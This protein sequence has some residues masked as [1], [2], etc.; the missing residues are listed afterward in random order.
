MSV[1]AFRSAFLR[2]FANYFWRR[3]YSRTTPMSLI[4]QSGSQSNAAELN[5]DQITWYAMLV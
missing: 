1:F 3:K 2:A 5:Q 4:S